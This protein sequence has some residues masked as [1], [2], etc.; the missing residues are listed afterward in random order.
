MISMSV[1]TYPELFYWVRVWSCNS[2]DDSILLQK[3]FCFTL[4]LHPTCSERTKFFRINT[5]CFM[6]ITFNLTVSSLVSA[7]HV[8]CE[9]TDCNGSCLGWHRSNQSFSFLLT[10][11]FEAVIQGGE[12]VPSNVFKISP[13][14]VCVQFVIIHPVKLEICLPKFWWSREQTWLIKLLTNHLKQC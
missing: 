8:R 3:L 5:F 4:Q 1:C 12:E 10:F 11:T 7:T 2:K 14:I 13:S 6:G 9:L